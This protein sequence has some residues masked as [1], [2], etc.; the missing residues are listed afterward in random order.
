MP[1]VIEPS[2]TG[3]SRDVAVPL[4]YAGW[5]LTGLIL[6]FVERRDR[7]VRF[8]AAQSL[9]V[10]GLIAVV[11]AAFGAGA[12]AA[13]SFLP[14]AFLPFLWASAVTWVVGVLLWVAVMLRAATGD[15]WRIPIAA[16]LA[17]RLTRRR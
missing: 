11:V 17:E 6:W 5:W 12:V 8:H 4:A 10:F 15:A 3:L 7:A 9:A 2:S 14:A 13:L 16:E 1:T